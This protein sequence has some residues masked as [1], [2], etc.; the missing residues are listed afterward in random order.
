MGERERGV[1]NLGERNKEIGWICRIDGMKNVRLLCFEWKMRLGI[2]SMLLRFGVCDVD[3][4]IVR[5]LGMTI[6]NAQDVF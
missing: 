3:E 6:S 2:L 1:E 4:D 5:Y